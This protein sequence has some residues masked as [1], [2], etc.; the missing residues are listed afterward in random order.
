M[1]DGSTLKLV[2]RDFE[3]ALL[4]D[5]REKLVEWALCISY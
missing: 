1:A 4:R 5:D 3:S 2:G